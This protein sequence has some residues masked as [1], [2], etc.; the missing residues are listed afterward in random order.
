MANDFLQGIWVEKYR[1]K[2][3]NEMVLSNANK[4]FLEQIK[5]KGETPNLMLAGA[6]G[7][8]KTSMAKVI[9][10]DILDCQYLYINASEENGINDIRSKVM[11][12]AQTRS[13]DSKIK[14]IILDECDFLSI[15]AMAA[16]RNIM[17]EYQGTTR[18]V[19]TCNYPFKVIPAIHSRCQEL[20]VTPPLNGVLTKCVN[21]LKAENVTVPGDVKEKLVSLIK[22]T[23]PDIRKCINRIQ[24]NT[25][26]GVLV[27]ENI[28]NIGGLSTEIWDMVLN[29][30]DITKIREYI[31]SK[32][33]DF[34]NDYHALL[35]QLFE[36]IY[37]SSLSV[38]KKR[39]A[40][41][42]VSEAMYRHVSV[43]DTEINVF[44]CIVQLGDI[45]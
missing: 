29:K 31:I 20:D 42:T 32:E 5:K 12:F 2:T 3:I 11:S 33:T 19:L 41:L 18:F 40:L 17:E 10:N 25:I 30:K 26:D 43:L 37:D 21:I 34:N 8:G 1:P 4:V 23:F 39:L 28:D 44:S 45:I 16:L 13:I 6:P 27:I 38:D 9:V 7:T 36:A 35:K 14:V 15:N 24:K 22:T